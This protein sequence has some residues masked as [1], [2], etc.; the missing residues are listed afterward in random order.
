MA[1]AAAADELARRGLKVVGVDPGLTTASSLVNQKWWQSGAI[2]DD[3]ELQAR[4]WRAFENMDPIAR[5]HCLTR[6][7]T[8]LADEAEA[9]EQRS[10]LW[11]ATG[12]RHRP[13]RHIA[14]HFRG[15]LGQPRATG[16]YWTPDSVLDFPALL[17]HLRSRADLLGAEL[18]MG[19][20]LTRLLR[21]GDRIS[22]VTYAYDGIEVELR[23]PQCII[24]AGPWASKLLSDIGVQL[25]VR[26]WKCHILELAG[27]QVGHITAWVNPPYVTLVPYRGYT[28]IADT[29]RYSTRDGDDREPIAEAVEGLKNDL[30][31][32]FP[33]LN[34]RVL[35]DA[36]VRV[37]IKAEAA[38]TK[39]SNPDLAVFD[40][41]YHGVRGLRV[42]FPGKASLAFLLARELAWQILAEL[43][44]GRLR[45]AP[46]PDLDGHLQS[47]PVGS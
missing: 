23:C 32:R 15:A 28:L 26:L 21:K 31:G 34:P 43:Q 20:R 13:V 12:I 40:E 47:T 11:R 38:G 46:G 5:H 42:V 2:Y 22:G 17:A 14:P 30:A 3:P 41:S 29:R 37:C 4:L 1:G 24:A 18:M 45:S 10:A 33:R 35:R 44:T 36:H 19:A 9:L 7:A 39:A 8:L 6:R 16:G 27:E 25:P